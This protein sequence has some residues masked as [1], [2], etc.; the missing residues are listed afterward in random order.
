MTSTA[1]STSS[2]HWTTGLWS[3]IACLLFLLMAVQEVLEIRFW[4]TMRVLEWDAE[5]YY[6]YLPATFIRGDVRDLAYVADL[7]DVL[8]PNNMSSFGL[9]HVKETGYDCIK[10]TYGTAL[11]E[12]PLFFAAH[13]Y[14]HGPWT[15]HPANGYSAPYQLGV[16][17][18]SVLFVFL[19]LLVL[20]KFLLRHV[21][22]PATALALITVALGTNAFFYCTV[23]SG[24]SHPYLFFLFALVIERTDTWHRAPSR[25]KAIGLGLALGLVLLTRP[26]DFIVVLVPLLWTY[27]LGW[28][29]KWDLV[30]RHRTHLVWAIAAVILPLLPQLLYW[31]AT[32]GHFI[33]Y[34]YR[35]EGFNWSDP[36]ILD[37]LFSY[38]KGWLVW[39]PLVALG[40]IGLG[41]M[42]AD[43]SERPLAWPIIA[44]FPPAL[45]GIFCWH[46]WWYGGGFGSRPLV[47]TL[48]LLALPVAVL[49]D[50]SLH[51]HRVIGA[52]FV[53]IVLCGVHLN[54]F[55]QRQFLISIVHWEDMTKERY[56]E[57]WGHETWEGLK[58]FP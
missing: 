44:F 18:S 8:H 10:Y 5:A 28:R 13:A 46:Q 9:F 47:E 27:G 52:L 6:H 25:R 43:R 58:P 50:R 53:V 38:R 22:D 57:I 24:M 11:F 29:S 23:N 41:V 34:S 40:F 26:I 55:Q 48:P 35:I 14:C 49:A 20:R 33:F 15:G 16:S 51:R 4:S 1:P 12:A 30:G 36:H 37:G 39:S 3:A 19:G 7:D 42:V 56:W 45:Y 32:T 54:L 17:L 21:G 31:K 2:R